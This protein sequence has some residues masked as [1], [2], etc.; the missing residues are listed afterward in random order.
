MVT[1]RVVVEGVWK[2]FRRGERH[3][4]IRDTLLAK[5]RRRAPDELS[6]QDFWSLQNLEFEVTAGE[7]LGIIGGN[8]SGKSTTLKLLTR[9]LRPT[10]GR[11]TTHGRIG[12]L[13]EVAAGFHPDLTGR[14][15]VYLQ[16]AIM[17]MRQSE[18]TRHF[19]EIVAFS[20]IESFIDTP[21]KRYSSGMNARLGFSIAAHLDPDILVIDEVLAVGDL[22]FQTRAF[23]RLKRLAKRGTPVIVVSH[24]LDRVRELC[25]SAL[26]LEQGR[27]AA[28]G[29]VDEVLSTYLNPRRASARSRLQVESLALTPAKGLYAPG[30]TVRLEASVVP[31]DDWD[32]QSEQ[33][34]IRVIDSAGR[35]MAGTGSDRL[36]I[37]PVPGRRLDLSLELDLNV[38][39][40]LYRLE[41]FVWHA[42][43]SEYVE[44]WGHIVMP[45]GS[46]PTGDDGD[47]YV[48]F[49]ADVARPTTMQMVDVH[50]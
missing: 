41:L 15:N 27:V 11:I 1:P 5:L 40:G 48:G 17:G 44:Q 16:G 26:L 18:I 50:A 7:S 33:I 31:A 21:V 34:G 10:R 32:R 12:A 38:V 35:V 30:E 6:G 49:R 14:E 28:V 37:T 39:D 42:G 20:G 4:T 19:D 23:D 36:G 22:A 45:V 3:D 46:D 25:T 13:I 29:G 2:K 9:I 43:R 24:Q 47:V 8:G